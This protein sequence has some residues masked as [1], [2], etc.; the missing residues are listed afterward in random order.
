MASIIF[1]VYAGF[2]KSPSWLA[3][4]FKN[5]SAISA[6]KIGLKSG[7]RAGRVPG[8]FIFWLNHNC[9]RR[10][11]QPSSKTTGASGHLP[12]AVLAHRLRSGGAGF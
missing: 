11:S 2:V 3:C 8:F 9:E 7:V 4:G 5:I 1:N 6:N 10:D 12:A